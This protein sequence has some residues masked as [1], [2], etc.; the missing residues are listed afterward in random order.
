MKR[1]DVLKELIKK[2]GYSIK[3]FA[4]EVDIPYTTLVSML[5]RD[6]GGASVDNVLKIC[7]AL[8]VSYEQLEEMARNNSTDVIFSD[9]IEIKT[10]AAHSDTDL[11]EEEQE[12]LREFA[13]YL[14]SKRK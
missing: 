13:K 12:E 2:R 5:Q 14:I 3:S 10:I 6:I 1:A 7:N 4:T 8:D 9:E 11:T